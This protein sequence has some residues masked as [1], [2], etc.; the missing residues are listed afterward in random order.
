MIVYELN[1]IDC[2]YGWT[3]W[4][5]VLAV[6][7][8]PNQYCC[9]IS[10]SDLCGAHVRARRLAKLL[11]ND[12]NVREGPYFSPL[13]ENDYGPT[14]FLLAWKLNNNGTTFIAS[15]YRLSWLDKD[16]S[17][18]ADDEDTT[19]LADLDRAKCLLRHLPPSRTPAARINAA[20]HEQ[21][22]SMRVLRHATHALNIP[23][24]LCRDIGF[25]TRSPALP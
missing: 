22:I 21:G 13:P 16:C 1:P 8:D 19:Y 7:A 12:D 15:P 4:E 9:Q 11:I 3:P 20:A 23:W 18:W 2:W 14:V 10:V 6:A 17:D 24:E 5:Q 25:A